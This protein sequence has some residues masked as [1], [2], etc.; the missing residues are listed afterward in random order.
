MG[1]LCLDRRRILANDSRATSLRSRRIA[2]VRIKQER[3]SLWCFGQYGI[4]TTPERKPAEISFAIYT[5][6]S[7]CWKPII[8]HI[9]C[10]AN[11]DSMPKIETQLRDCLIHFRFPLGLRLVRLG[12]LL[13]GAVI[14]VF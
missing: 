7:K 1:K 6:K 8:M 9:I 2:E 3:Y 5:A 12:E 14:A 13:V 4:A 11:Q 10:C